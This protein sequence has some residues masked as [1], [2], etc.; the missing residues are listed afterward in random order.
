MSILAMPRIPA[1]TVRMNAKTR[2]RQRLKLQ[3]AISRLFDLLLD[4]M[5]VEEIAPDPTT[6]RMAWHMKGL[7]ETFISKSGLEV[8][9]LPINPDAPDLDR[10]WQL[11]KKRKNETAK[12]KVRQAKQRH[13]QM[14]RP[15]SS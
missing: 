9:K 5:A 12:R 14:Q 3:S 13:R 11:I 8:W 2:Y 7:L 1:Y 6:A 15:R 10:F 4:H